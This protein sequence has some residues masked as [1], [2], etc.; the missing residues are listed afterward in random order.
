MHA[1]AQLSPSLP[2]TLKARL[3]SQHRLSPDA[4]SSSACLPPTSDGG[5]DRGRMRCRGH[6]AEGEGEGRTWREQPRP[7]QVRK[8][9]CGQDAVSGNIDSRVGVGEIRV[10][11]R[12]SSTRGL[13]SASED[14][15]TP[16]SATN[17]PG[18]LLLQYR[19]Q[20]IIDLEV[21]V[22]D[23]SLINLSKQ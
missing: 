16:D 1:P 20:V 9:L 7:C 21:L 4:C 22:N 5:G 8:S 12:T 18:C 13:I 6:R 14:R 19:E 10:S 15:F 2:P 23:R 11:F 17:T 3:Y